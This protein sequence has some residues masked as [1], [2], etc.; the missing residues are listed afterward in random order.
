[1]QLTLPFN[2]WWFVP[3]DTKPQPPARTWSSVINRA[4][5]NCACDAIDAYITIRDSLLSES[6]VF[7]TRQMLGR[8]LFVNEIVELL[9]KPPPPRCDGRHRPGR[10]LVRER[11]RCETVKLQVAELNARLAQTGMAEPSTVAS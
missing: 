8:V 7:P 10:D 11:E 2:R 4:K 1:M 9:L 5:S 3:S 6:A